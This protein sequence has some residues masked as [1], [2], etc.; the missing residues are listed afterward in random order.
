M[1]RDG[2]RREECTDLRDTHVFLPARLT[3]VFILGL[4]TLLIS[5]VRVKDNGFGVWPL[6][7]V[8]QWW[9][10]VVQGLR[11][12]WAVGSDSLR[13]GRF[14]NRIPMEARFSAPVQTGHGA[15]PASCTMGTGSF[16]GL[17]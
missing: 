11:G 3:A 12:Q 15:H 8:V 2:W 6:C 1:T 4:K 10:M 7:M 13:A 17:K 5:A 16:P 14:G 9:Y